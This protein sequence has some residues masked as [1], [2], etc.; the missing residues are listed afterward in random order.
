MKDCIVRAIDDEKSF[1][2]FVASTTNMI[3]EVRKIHNT[4]PVIT[5]ALGRVMTA[6]SIMGSM[7]KEDKDKITIQFKGNGPIKTILSTAD[8]NGNA[9][10]YIGNPNVNLPLKPNGK[11]D[12][13]GAVGKGKITVIKDIGFKKPYIGQS[14]IVSGEIAEDLTHYFV[15]SEQQ[16]SA[17]SLGVLINKDL[18]V[19]ASGGFIVQVLPNISEEQLNKLEELI[20]NTKSISTIIDNANQPED[21]LNY[22]FG[23]FKMQVIDK[24]NILLLRDCSRERMERALISLGKDELKSMINEDGEAELVCHFC[25]SKYYFSKKELETLL[26]KLK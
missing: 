8:S 19:K 12:V 22:L 18:S 3:E 16:P 21:I 2:V 9:K 6:S 1:R 7:L 26:K 15:K 20:N 5:A 23:N 14:N 10:G 24:K 4:T 11:L 25:K 13:G 17:V